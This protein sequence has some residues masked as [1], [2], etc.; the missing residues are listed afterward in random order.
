MDPRA[1][2]PCK[3][4]PLWDSYKNQTNLGG[5]GIAGLILK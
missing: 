3:R 5:A 4:N 1:I 2:H